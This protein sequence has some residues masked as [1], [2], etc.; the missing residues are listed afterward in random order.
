MPDEWVLSLEEPNVIHEIKHIDSSEQPTPVNY[1][2][3]LE[4]FMSVANRNVCVFNQ[5][6][7]SLTNLYSVT[8]NTMSQNL[9]P[10]NFAFFNSEFNRFSAMSDSN[11]EVAHILKN[12]RRSRDY[13]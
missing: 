13:V 2:M 7:E 11:L 5:L 8:G 10:A 6:N 12:L 1:I 3:R 9:H 4:P